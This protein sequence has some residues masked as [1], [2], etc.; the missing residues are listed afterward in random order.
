MVSR[1]CHFEVVIV[2]CLWP[3]TVARGV[4]DGWKFLPNESQDCEKE[5]RFASRKTVTYE[6]C[7]KCQQRSAV[8]RAMGKVQRRN[9]ELSR[10]K[11]EA[12]AK[13][14][15]NENEPSFRTNKFVCHCVLRMMEKT[16]QSVELF[17]W[18]KALWVASVNAVLLSAFQRMKEHGALLL[19]GN[20][21]REIH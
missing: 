5:K 13:T 14:T 10:K 20:L 2:C 18:I 19:V 16:S 6:K 17:A 11:R 21:R 9:C 12:G 3:W 4:D 7:W 15:H 1:L 8:M